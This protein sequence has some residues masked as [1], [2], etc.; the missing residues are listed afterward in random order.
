[1]GVKYDNSTE[2][3]FMFWEAMKA[4]MTETVNGI[5][6]QEMYSQL[7]IK[8]KLVRFHIDCSATV[9]EL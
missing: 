3:E 8:E 6:E 7:F 2:E 4:V 5:L 9:N 1:M